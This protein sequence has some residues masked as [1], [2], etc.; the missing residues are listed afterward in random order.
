MTRILTLILP[1]GDSIIKEML[2]NT[3]VLDAPFSGGRWYS[4]YDKIE[5]MASFYNLDY[6]YEK[7]IIVSKYYKLSNKP[8]DA[9]YWRKLASERWAETLGLANKITLTERL[10]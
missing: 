10:I 3:P 8:D 5:N 7:Y 9:E 2:A 6:V 4:I 1:S